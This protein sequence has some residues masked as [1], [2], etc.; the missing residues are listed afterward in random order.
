M[1]GNKKE[2]MDSIPN[3]QQPCDT[4]L[5]PTDIDFDLLQV[6][7]LYFIKV[8]IIIIVFLGGSIKPTLCR[9]HIESGAT[10]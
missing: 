8:F 9:T 5:T 1:V 2:F 10:Q 3:T 6:F 7:F 4:S